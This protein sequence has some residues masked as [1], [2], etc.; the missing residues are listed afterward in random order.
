MGNIAGILSLTCL[1]YF[2]N[3]TSIFRLLCLY[4]MS[5]PENK[6]FSILLEKSDQWV[7]LQ[8]LRENSKY[9]YPLR[10]KQQI[11]MP[12]NR[13]KQPMDVPPRPEK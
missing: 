6:M 1:A 8:G 10:E 11:G 5:I 2:N 4:T 13:E 9:K 3:L 7:Y 12:P